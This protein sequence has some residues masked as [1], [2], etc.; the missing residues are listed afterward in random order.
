MLKWNIC[1]YYTNEIKVG[2]L[3]SHVRTLRPVPKQ[4]QKSFSVC[5]THQLLYNM[6]ITTLCLILNVF[7]YFIV[8]QNCMIYWTPLFLEIET[9]CDAELV[10][11]LACFSIKQSCVITGNSNSVQ[12]RSC[13]YKFLHVT[14]NA[15]MDVDFLVLISAGAN[16]MFK[17][18]R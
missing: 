2:N 16:Y 5:C 8:Y 18:I 4:E 12:R 14:T 9:L 15:D 11:K 1:M 17:K 7:I 3:L 13:W 10:Y 6:L